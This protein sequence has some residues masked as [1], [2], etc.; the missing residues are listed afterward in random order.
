[1]N[2]IIDIT[3]PER[4]D[5]KDSNWNFL[6]QAK[7]WEKVFTYLTTNKGS[8]PRSIEA[9]SNNFSTFFMIKN[10]RQ[11]YGSIGFSINGISIFWLNLDSQKDFSLKRTEET[12][13]Q[14]E[15]IEKRVRQDGKLEEDDIDF[16]TVLWNKYSG[17]LLTPQSDV[18]LDI[19]KPKLSSTL[20]QEVRDHALSLI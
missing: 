8:D 4:M 17:K 20:D 6:F 9:W 19:T 7:V 10:E 1:M 15:K 16:M 14:L 12:Y 11:I 2:I 13:Q 3:H 18:S 5:R